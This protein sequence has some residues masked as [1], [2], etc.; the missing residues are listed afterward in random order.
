MTSPDDVLALA[1]AVE[2]RYRTKPGCEWCGREDFQI[3]MQDH[4]PDCPVPIAQWLIAEAER[5]E[6]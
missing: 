1:R 3:K 5:G 2:T 4:A 6:G